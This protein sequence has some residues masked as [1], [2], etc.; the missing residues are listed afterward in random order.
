VIEELLTNIIKYGYKGGARGV[1]EVSIHPNRKSLRLEFSDNAMAFDP[2][3]LEKKAVADSVENLK[4][5]GLGLIIV[6]KSCR[7]MKYKRLQGRN[8]LS[9]TIPVSFDNS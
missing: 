5:G 3:S 8:N 7:R 9:L 6:S 4:I 1:V 2:T